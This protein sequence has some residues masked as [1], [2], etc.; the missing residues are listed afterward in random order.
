MQKLEGT[1]E[2]IVYNN[3]V[4][5]YTVCEI[6][7]EGELITVIGYMPES[8]VGEQIIAHGDWVEH[9]E[10]G[11]QFRAEYCEKAVPTDES[12]IARYLASGQ[13]SGIGKVTAE[14][15][16]EMFGSDTFSIIETEPDKLKAVKGMTAAKA[17][18]LHTKYIEQIGVKE[19]ITFLQKF[20]IS[21]NFAVKVYQRFNEDSVKAVKANPYILADEIDGITFE[22][23][24][25]VAQKLGVEK[26][27]VLRIK[28]GI[29]YTLG[30]A[31]I[32]NGHTYLPRYF[33][34]SRTANLL[35]VD[36]SEAE[37]ALMLALEENIA[38]LENMGEFDAIYL[39]SYHDAESETARR[40]AA[41]TSTEFDPDMR[42]IE[43]FITEIEEESEIELAPAQLSAVKNSV[44]SSAM[45]ITGGPGTG[46]TTI[47][48]SI[49]ALMDK[50]DKSVLLAAPTGRA[51]KRMT[52]LCGIESKTIHRLLE[53]GYNDENLTQQFFR[54]EE[55]PLDADVVIID[56]MS[57][58][59]IMLM[60]SL[61]KAVPLGARLIMV[62][63]SDQ[64]PSVGAGNVLRD[65]IESDI[66]YTVKLSEIFRQAEESMIVV[67]AHKINS[68]GYPTLN[69]KNSDFYF[70]HRND[71]GSLCDTIAN[72]CLERLPKAYGINSISQ[73]Q[74]IT[75]MRKSQV[76]VFGLNSILQKSLNP[77]AADK[78]EKA[79]KYITYRLGD[80]VMQIKN[81]YCL[82]WAK[83]V[84]GKEEEGLGVFN[85]D[86]GFIVDVNHSDSEIV[87]KFDDERRVAYDFTQLDEL[88]LAYAITVHKSQGSEFDVV[89]MPMI[90]VHPLLMT[91]N[92]LYTAVTRAKTL[93]VLVGQEEIMQQ[94]ILNSNE[95]SRY[96]GL[97]QRLADYF[98]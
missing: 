9:P 19:I 11:D 3:A 49:I 84:G 34:V 7:H 13:F 38:V 40:I 67:N 50:L 48:K 52:E 72:L 35:G 82:Q 45:V 60:N 36:Q 4:N 46:K 51:A 70:V 5:G 78:P 98:R 61:L 33:V 93:V 18:A 58:V 59:D 10:Y 8:A 63:D 64:L 86:V 17:K 20:G 27:S 12:D 77:P 22:T 69:E 66:V 68:G 56:E 53:V 62:G 39:N 74:V 43:Q 23:A 91:R 95:Q 97:K 21:P 32:S 1:I 14:R 2:N 25:N 41:L 75:P 28:A 31:A 89:V 44:K 87:V 85:G 26:N 79:L 57:M 81:N 65:I 88:E 37:S 42:E 30:K 90:E 73:I 71:A 54:N 94:F 80:K 47:I 29:K 96:S 24:D 15:I 16:V 92:L 55:N 83:D 6:S 76:G